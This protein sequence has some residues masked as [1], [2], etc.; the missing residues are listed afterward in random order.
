MILFKLIPKSEAIYVEKILEKGP[1]TPGTNISNLKTTFFDPFDNKVIL[2]RKEI[3]R[4]SKETAKHIVD[5]KKTID[6]DFEQTNFTLNIAYILKEI[7]ESFVNTILPTILTAQSN[8]EKLIK[9]TAIKDSND[10][11][12]IAQDFLE[13]LDSI[14]ARLKKV[15]GDSNRV[16]Q[17]KSSGIAFNEETDGTKLISK[18]T[19][20]TQMIEDISKERGL[21]VE[22]R[23]I[24]LTQEFLNSQID[25]IQSLGDPILR[26]ITDPNNERNWE[27]LQSTEFYAEGNTSVIIVRER[28]GHYMQK[29]AVNNPSTLIKSQLN[30]SR[31]VASGALEV[32]SAFG[33]VAG[34]PI[35]Q[36]PSEE[37]EGT[38]TPNDAQPNEIAMEAQK[39]NLDAE[40]HRR[41]N[42]RIGLKEEIKSLKA[43]VNEDPGRPGDGKLVSDSI[44]EKVKAILKAQLYIFGEVSPLPKPPGGQPLEG[45]PLEGQPLE[46][47]P[48]EGQPLEGQPLEG[49]PLEGQPL[50]GQP[51]EGQ[52]LEGQP[53][54]GQPLEGQ[55]LEGQPLEGQPLEGQPLEGQPLEG[56]PLEG[57]PVEGQPLEGQPLEGQ[58]LEGQPLEGQPLEGQPLEG[59]PLEGQPLGEHSPREQ[60]LGNQLG[61]P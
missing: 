11:K 18:W 37:T 2:K 28:P 20:K 44:L 10:K 19:E 60:D 1:Y 12:I 30:I 57:Q 61:D 7:D 3:L 23:N 25:R 6:I 50:E 14:I 46:G 29:Q 34:I 47:Q 17:T 55:P 24:A 13:S 49:Q 36:I 48:L 32:L 22:T 52:P 38:S 16:D 26:E 33:G 59:Q 43:Q 35:P 45:Q 53:L 21:Q 54:E 31:S 27:T 8:Y 9:S 39:T 42:A 4:L 58:P 51:L 56:Q 41:R 40:I 5:N 15:K